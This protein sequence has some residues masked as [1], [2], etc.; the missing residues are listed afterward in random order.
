MIMI[1]FL[2]KWFF[3]DDFVTIVV[4]TAKVDN[5]STKNE[6]KTTF[7]CGRETIIPLQF[8]NHK[9]EWPFQ[10]AP[11]AIPILGADFLKLSGYH[12]VS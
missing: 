11:V 1:C 7:F 8:G 9:F 2:C 12:V 5:I 3:S 10:L 4:K 6:K